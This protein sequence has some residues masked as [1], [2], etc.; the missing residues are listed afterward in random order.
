MFVDVWVWM[1][2]R[3]GWGWGGVRGLGHRYLLCAVGC[4][5]SIVAVSFGTSCYHGSSDDVRAVTMALAMMYE[6]LP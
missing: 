1:E 5:F 4:H 2:W 6:L 3:R